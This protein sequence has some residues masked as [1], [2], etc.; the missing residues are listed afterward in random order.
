MRDIQRAYKDA[1]VAEY[2][3][4]TRAGRKAEADHVK[5]QLSE[6]FGYSAADADADEASRESADEP[7]RESTDEPKP[8]EATVEPKP[9]RRGP[10]QPVG[11]KAAD[12]D[13]SE[14]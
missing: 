11:R 7:V 4:L 14:G 12:K 2:E 13:S 6:Q 5:Q 10:R 8:P 1:M 9:G 3:A